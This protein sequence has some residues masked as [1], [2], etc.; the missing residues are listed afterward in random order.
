MAIDLTQPLT[1]RELNTPLTEAEKQQL[2]DYERR[3]RAYHVA[4]FA[5]QVCGWP[6]EAE[7]VL[8]RRSRSLPDF[9]PTIMRRLEAR[10]DY[11]T[12]L[13]NWRA[14]LESRIL[15]PVTVL[16]LPEANLSALKEQFDREHGQRTTPTSRRQHAREFLA[17]LNKG[18]LRAHFDRYDER[19]GEAGSILND[20]LTQL[21]EQLEAYVNACC[22]SY[23]ARLPP[24]VPPDET[25]AQLTLRQVALLHIYT[26]QPVPKSGADEIARRYGHRGGPRLYEHYRKLVGMPHNRTGVTGRAVAP[27]AEDITVVIA[28]LTGSARQ[29]AE[30]ERRTLETKERP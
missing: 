20:V 23:E 4:T 24:L 15:G 21:V 17:Q 7:T 11:R 5:A 16:T 9:E 27:M 19:T 12:F 26:G 8:A 10:R 29:Q 25:A 28:H 22:A 30:S 1:E 6:P 3:V 13:Q 14:G 2:I 18:E